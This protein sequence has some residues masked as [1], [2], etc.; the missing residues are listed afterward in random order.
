MYV[1]GVLQADQDALSN[2]AYNAEKASIG[3]NT[4]SGSQYF[5]G[6]IDE[7]RFASS[8]RSGE[9]IEAQFKS[10][11]NT[12]NTFGGEESQSGG[13]RWYGTR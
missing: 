1:D 10:Q 3:K 6:R 8:A 5:D 2:V 13:G 11:G 12:F 7:V 4:D 9:W